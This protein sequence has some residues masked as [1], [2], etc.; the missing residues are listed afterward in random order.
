MTERNDFRYTP[1]LIIPPRRQ[2][3]HGLKRPFNI[4]K[5]C[6]L[7]FYPEHGTYWYDQ[8]INNYH[9]TI[10]GATAV[11]NCRI[12][13]GYYFDGV[14]DIVGYYDDVFPQ[15]PFSLSIWINPSSIAANTYFFTSNWGR[16]GFRR[17]G[18]NVNFRFYDGGAYRDNTIANVFAVGDWV[19][20]VGTKDSTNGT[21][22]YVNGTLRNTESGANYLLDVVFLG[23]HIL[24]GASTGAAGAWLDGTN[25]YI[26]EALL[27]DR[28]LE[29]WEIKAMYEAG[30]PGEI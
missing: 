12:G 25:A 2:L 10:T 6:L 3:K 21:S 1:P 8:S 28:V 7:A 23:Q 22:V 14:D 15:Q 11:H 26:D 30:R 18:A 5:D 13:Q 29:P 17:V 16:C 4:D 19:H 24:I 20:L 27:F 9:G